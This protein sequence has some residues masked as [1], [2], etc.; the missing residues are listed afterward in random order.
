MKKENSNLVNPRV[1][2]NSI[3]DLR[4]FSLRL[5]NNL[6]GITRSKYGMTV[7]FSNRGFTLIELLVVVLIIGILAAVALPQYQKAVAKSRALEAIVMLRKIYQ[8]QQVYFLANGKYTDDLTQLDITIPAQQI[9]RYAYAN[10][11][12][13]SEYSYGCSNGSC[14]ARVAVGKGP[15]FEQPLNR[16]ELD[17]FAWGSVQPDNSICAFLAGRQANPSSNGFTYYK[18]DQF[19]N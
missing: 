8:A 7:L 18:L 1:R 15:S 13:P 6:R 10:N 3:E 5:I 9:G 19:S 17:C 2:L 12:R 14:T 11:A 16:L 4:Y